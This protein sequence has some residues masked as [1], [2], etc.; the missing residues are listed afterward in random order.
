MTHDI[1]GMAGLTPEETPVRREN[2]RDPYPPGAR[3]FADFTGA[4]EAAAAER[5]ARAAVDHSGRT[6]APPTPCPTKIALFEAATKVTPTP[7]NDNTPPAGGLR[8]N[9]G[10]PR[11]D[12]LPPDALDE[13]VKV[14]TIGAEKYADRNWEK[15]FPWMSCYGSMMRHIQAWARGEDLDVGPNGESG[16]YPDDPSIHMRWTGLPHMAL[17]S[18]N[19]MA[20][21][22]FYLRGV[23]V[24]DRLKSQCTAGSGRG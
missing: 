17:A 22:T 7:D 1:R 13:L 11:Y 2:V 6:D 14:Y 23:G 10:K 24:D 8:Y 9:T 3:F 20:L 5:L 16:A 15:G 18:W 12:L 19:A 21:T 4:A